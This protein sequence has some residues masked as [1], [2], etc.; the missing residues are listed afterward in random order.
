M[1]VQTMVRSAGKLINNIVKTGT[2][3]L[4]DEAAIQSVVLVNSLSVALS[5]LLLL[6]GPFFYLLTGNPTSYILPLR[7]A[8]LP[9]FL[10]I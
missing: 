8:S 2:K 3:G 10:Y 5:L 9:R 6:L 1:S 7:N 4:H